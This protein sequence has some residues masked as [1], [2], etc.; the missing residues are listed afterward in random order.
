MRV[1]RPQQNKQTMTARFYKQKKGLTLLE[2]LIVVSFIGMLSLA[3]YT[4]LSNG[5]KVWQ[6]SQELIV[7]EEMAI[8][9]DRIAQDLHNTFD[10]SQIPFEGTEYTMSFA[11]FVSVVSEEDGNHIDQIGRVEYYYDFL[12]DG[13][14]VRKANYSQAVDN[15]F[16]KPRLL[17]SDVSRVRFYYYYRTQ[18]GQ[19][20]MDHALDVKPSG[21]EIEL[22]FNNEGV[23]KTMTKFISIPINS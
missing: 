10:F 11:S 16:G 15:R 13:L 6:K 18:D 8:F 5:L 14:F 19:V 22:Q 20:R 17:I 12:E 3:I 4:T 9:F 23:T 2:I 7:E 21:V 1:L